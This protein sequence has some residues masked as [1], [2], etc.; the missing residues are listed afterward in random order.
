MQHYLQVGGGK[1][2]LSYPAA[3]DAETVEW[4]VAITDKETYT[5]STFSVGDVSTY[6]FIHES[7]TQEQAFKRIIEHYKA[8]CVNMPSGRL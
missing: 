4:P 1:D 8:W 2:G 6:I 3:D 7:L 5:R